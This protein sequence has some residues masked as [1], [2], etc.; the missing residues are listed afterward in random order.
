MYEVSNYPAS[1][2]KVFSVQYLT[3]CASTRKMD[4]I[5]IASFYKNKPKSISENSLSS[6]VL[7]RGPGLWSNEAGAN[8]LLLPW[9]G[10]TPSLEQIWIP[11][12]LW[13]QLSFECKHKTT[14]RFILISKKIASMGGLVVM[15]NDQECS[16]ANGTTSCIWF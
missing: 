7:V 8:S 11:Y 2:W 16:I 13:K 6:L 4:Q 5:E 1:K 12:L 9:D 15:D 3:N 14:K 10:D